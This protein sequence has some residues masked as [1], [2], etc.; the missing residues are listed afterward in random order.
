MT[1]KKT[2]DTKNQEQSSQSQTESVREN[3]EVIQVDHLTRVEGHGNIVVKLD[4]GGE[5]QECTW[6][7]VEAPRFFEAMVQ[8]RP[9]TDIHH[10]VSR[11]CGI[12]S[13]GHQLCSIQAT[14]NAFGLEV[15]NQT[16]KLRKLAL[17]A[18]NLQS[19]LLHMGYLVLPDLLGVDSILPVAETHREELV[20]LVACRRIANEFSQIICGRTTHPQRLVVGGMAKLPEQEE[21]N[22]LMAKLEEAGKRL[23]NVVDLFVALG[24][25]WPEFERPTEY[26][27]L[28]SPGEY[29]LYSGQIQTSLDQRRPALFYEQVTNEYCVPH[30]TAKWTRNVR[31]SYLV[32]ALSRFNLNYNQLFPKAKAAAQKLG[33]APQVHNPFLNTLAQ[34]VECVHSIQESMQIISG[35]L[36]EGIR[37]EKPVQPRITAAQGVG[38]VEVPRGILFHKYEYNDQGRV[39]AADCVIPTNQNHANI[40]KDMD[41]IKPQL[42]GLDP[43]SIELRLSM[44][45]RGYDPCIS[46]STHMVDL[47]SSRQRLVRFV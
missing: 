12:C 45:V 22:N 38:A 37:E 28:T 24:D 1:K 14:E 42:S 5:V 11:I 36:Q 26:V 46:C 6:E 15:S 2:K 21:L 39:M 8:D 3:P 44:L 40:Q 20:N 35:L 41:A 7:V 34:L 43:Q 31:D 30:S 32:G 25:K 17:H 19:H 27:A 47:S 23:E 4:P 18:E 13:I 10:I 16:L 9:Y 29:A 33:L